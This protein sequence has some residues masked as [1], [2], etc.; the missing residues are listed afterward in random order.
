MRTVILFLLITAV[1]Y[2]LY[3]N[4]T[5]DKLPIK[6]GSTAPDFAL[7]TLDGKKV[8]LSDMKGKGIFLNFWGSWCKPC[9]KEMP[10]MENQYHFYKDK[11]IE[12]L[13]V[14]IEESDLAVNQFVKRHNLTFPILMDR[15]SEVTKLYNIGPIPTTF[16]IDENGKILKIITGSMT[17]YDV[18][19]YMELIVPKV[20]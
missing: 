12:I 19:K 17:E 7:E 3:A 14:N 2:T 8:Q 10:Y 9:E 20:N 1:V 5:K 15:K 16:L 18:K 13:A 4:F 6:V 11:N